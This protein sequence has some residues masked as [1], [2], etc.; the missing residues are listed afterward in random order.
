MPIAAAIPRPRRGIDAPGPAITVS[1]H[2]I[3][4][5]RLPIPGYERPACFI[6]SNR[7]RGGQASPG[8]SRQSIFSNQKV[9]LI[10]DYRTAIPGRIDLLFTMSDNTGAAAKPRTPEYGFSRTPSLPADRLVQAGQRRRADRPA[11]DRLVEPDGIEPTT[12]CL[13]SRRSPN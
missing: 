4:D 11:I 3:A 10:T 12:S 6:R 5:F 1:N 9:L 2:P 13:Q 7:R 8:R